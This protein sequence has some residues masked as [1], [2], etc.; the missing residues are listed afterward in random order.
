[1]NS[2]KES[3]EGEGNVRE[4]PPSGRSIILKL[5]QDFLPAV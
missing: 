4:T 1:M 2:R 5:Q 3:S